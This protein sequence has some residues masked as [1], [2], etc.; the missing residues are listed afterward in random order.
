MQPHVQLYTNIWIH[1]TW[2]AFFSSLSF[3]FVRI[4][5]RCVLR[6]FFR[7]AKHSPVAICAM[8]AR[9]IS[10]AWVYHARRWPKKIYKDLKPWCSVNA[11]YY[12]HDLCMHEN[13][14]QMAENLKIK[15]KALF[16]RM[17]WFVSKRLQ[18]YMNHNKEKTLKKRK[19]GPKW[20]SECKVECLYFMNKIHFF[21]LFKKCGC[22]SMVYFAVHRYINALHTNHDLYKMLSLICTD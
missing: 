13:H 6:F 15:E 5:A 2:F 18:K 10:I 8:R 17:T 14:H 21:V 9:Y 20:D 4:A 12:I 11:L 3:P 22:H 19:I 16:I 7:L 1:W